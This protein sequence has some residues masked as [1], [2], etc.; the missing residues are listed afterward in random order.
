MNAQPYLE[1]FRK[2]PGFLPWEKEYSDH[3]Y[4]SFKLACLG[5]HD[6][7]H[8]RLNSLWHFTSV[9]RYWKQKPQFGTLRRG[10]SLSDLQVTQRIA[11]FTLLKG[12]AIH[13]TVAVVLAWFTHHGV[14]LTPEQ[15]EDVCS[16]VQSKCAFGKSSKLISSKA[17]DRRAKNTRKVKAWRQAKRQQ[18]GIKE[19]LSS[20][21]VYSL[22]P[23]TRS[24]KGDDLDIWIDNLNQYSTGRV[25]A[26]ALAL[27][28]T[29]D[30]V[31]AHLRRLQKRGLVRKTDDSVFFRQ[32]ETDGY[33]IRFRDDGQAVTTN[34]IFKK[35]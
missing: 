14:E 16:M 29:N 7:A 24:G 12:L 4:E 26:L 34:E 35:S 9:S 19:R 23:K 3:H 21:A 28:A 2:D 11:Y 8:S 17:K 32:T 25:E 30:A 18:H 31:R 10:E 6:F 13:E 1:Y 33:P 22:L 5:L 20:E 27:D 15:V